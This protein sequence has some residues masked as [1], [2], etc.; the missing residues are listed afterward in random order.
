[1][2]KNLM[3]RLIAL[4]L[5]GG[6]LLS[7]TGVY[8][9]LAT[10]ESTTS[11]YTSALVGSTAE[12]ETT[13]EGTEVDNPTTQAPTTTKPEEST[14][15]TTKP[16]AEK[17]ATT[18]PP[19]TTK[20]AETT[21]K[22][23]TTT[24]P[25]IVEE[26]VTS[27][28][29][30]NEGSLDSNGDW[31]GIDGTINAAGTE[32]NPYN[33][34][35][36][37]DFLRMNKWINDP[38][39][40]NK[41]FCLTSNIDFTGVTLNATAI[42]AQ[43]A[44]A[45]GVY[46]LVSVDPAL[47]NNANVYFVLTT[48]GIS[49]N[50]L[51][52]MTINVEGLDYVSVF[53]YVNS[54]SKIEDLHVT[55]LSITNTNSQAMAA[56]F[57]LKNEGSI[58]G[59]VFDGVTVDISKST[60]TAESFM[61]ANDSLRVYTGAAGVVVDNSGIIDF[62]KQYD[63]S[64]LSRPLSNVTVKSGRPYAG[65]LVAQNRGYVNKVRA[66]NLNV[67]G[68][69][70]V[71]GVVG[72]NM[73]ARSSS[74]TGVYYVDVVYTTRGTTVTGTN[75]VGGIAG[76]NKGRVQRSKIT[77]DCKSSEIALVS[78]RATI[79]LN[80]K[81]YAGG[82]VGYNEGDVQICSAL[83]V[84]AYISSTENGAAYGGI[85]GYSNYT[86][87]NCV[88]TGTTNGAGTLTDIERYVGGIVGKAETSSFSVQ[89]CYTLVRILNSKA[90]LGAVVGFGGDEAYKANR[91]RNVF[92]S[93]IISTRPSPVSYGGT[94]SKE[95]D[96][97]FS[98]PY[99]VAYHD[100]YNFSFSKNTLSIS[101][102]QFTFS[103]WS[104]ATFNVLGNF[105]TAN[106]PSNAVINK[107]TT[108]MTYGLS[109]K[110]ATGSKTHVFYEVDITL[111]SGIGF[112]TSVLSKE[113]MEFGILN[114]S[115]S[116]GTMVNNTSTD[117]VGTKDD[118]FII[119]TQL[120]MLEMAPAAHFVIG[121]ASNNLSIGNNDFVSPITFWGSID[122]KGS[123]ISYNATKPFFKGIYGSRDDSMSI[124]DSTTHTSSSADGDDKVENLAYGVVKNFS[125]VL[126]RDSGGNISNIFGNI[127]NA[128]VKNISVTMSSALTSLTAT[129]EKSG[130]FAK[131]VYGNSYLYECYVGLRE[132]GEQITCNSNG[133]N[134]ISGFIGTI[135]AENA[136]IDNCGSN[137]LI[138][139]TAT[140]STNNAIFVGTIKSLGGAI[141]NCYATGGIKG[142][143]LSS[144]NYLFAGEISSSS[145]Q[146]HN[147]YFSPSDYYNSTGVYKGVTEGIRKGSFTGTCKNYSF[148]AQNSGNN[149]YS[150]ITMQIASGQTNVLIN[151]VKNF[152]R[153]SFPADAI[154]LASYFTL[155][156][157]N[158]TNMTADAI[159]KQ[160]DYPSVTYTFIGGQNTNA[161][162]IVTHKETGLTARLS[163][164]NSSDLALEDNYYVIRTPIDLYYLVTNQT[165]MSA[166]G[167]Y[168]YVSPSSKIKIAADID[169]TGY[170]ID[171]FG[172]LNLPFQGEI[173]G[174]KGNGEPVTISNLSYDGYFPGFFQAVKG[175]TISGIYLDNIT[176]AGLSS[177]AALVN[178]VY[179]NVNISNCKVTNSTVAAP[180]KSGAIIG[181]IQ[182]PGSN[183]T[184]TITSVIENCTVEN[185]TITSTAQ[186]GAAQVGGII[187]TVGQGSGN[188][189]RSANIRSCTVNNCEITGYG[190]Q[191]GG[192]VG[193][194]D[195]IDNTIEGCTV[196]NTDIYSTN[197]AI[198]KNDAFLGGIAG[199]FGGELI[200]N[201][202]VDTVT[203]SGPGAAGVVT[204]LMNLEG[205]TSTISN[206]TVKNSNILAEN[207]DFGKFAGG[208]MSIVS[209]ATTYA[210]SG[211]G[212]KVVSNCKITADTTVKSAVSGGIVANVDT[213]RGGLQI[214]NCTNLGT[215][216]TTG[217]R[218]S[219]TD[220]AG[221]IIG[222]IAS[223][224]ATDKM[225]IIGCLSQGTVKGVSIL[226]G[227]IGIH[228]GQTHTGESKL[229]SNTYITAKFSST[230][231][232]VTK[233]L[234][235]G[236]LGSNNMDSNGKV[237]PE[238]SD[239]V[240]YSSLSN[241][242]PLFGNSAAF[243]YTSYTALDPDTGDEVKKYVVYDMQLG[244]DQEKGLTIGIAST[245]TT[246]SAL[247]RY[248]PYVAQSI[249]GYVDEN[250]SPIGTNSIQ[251]KTNFNTG[252]T[253][254][255]GYGEAFSHT[256]GGTSYSIASGAKLSSAL[257]LPRLAVDNLPECVDSNGD[258]FA[259][260][261][262]GVI[263][264][265]DTA[266]TKLK[267]GTSNT[268]NKPSQIQ[269]QTYDKKCQAVVYTTYTGTVNG[270][271]VPFKVGFT[272]IVNGDHAFDGDGTR[273]NPYIIRDAEDLLSIKMHHDNPSVIN[274][275]TGEK[276]DGAK[277]YAEGTYYE[278]VND[279]DMSE[280]LSSTL[281]F[282][283]IG[284]K[285]DPFKATISSTN[286]QNFKISNIIINNPTDKSQ[287][288]YNTAYG[289]N[290][291]Y[292]TAFGVFGYTDGATISDL[293]FEN[294]NIVAN[295]TRNDSPGL[296]VGAVVGYAQNTTISNVK[297]S[298]V[299][300][301]NVE[302]GANADIS[303]SMSAGGIVGYA[304]TDTKLSD[305]SVIGA[306]ADQGRAKISSLYAIGGIVGSTENAT[307]VSITNARVENVN[308]ENR[309]TSGKSVAGGIAGIFTGTLTGSMVDEIQLDEN[310]N[311]ITVQVRKPIVVNSVN[312]KGNVV[313]GAVGTT[314]EMKLISYVPEH[315]IEMLDVSNV[316]LDVIRETNENITNGVAGGILGKTGEY[317]NTQ[318]DDCTVD[319]NT[320]VSTGLTAGGIV[321]KFNGNAT[322]HAN[323]RS[324]LH[325]TN[326]KS[327]AK[328]TQEKAPKDDDKFVTYTADIVGVGSILGVA[329]YGT[330]VMNENDN[331]ANLKI[332]NS[333][334]GGEVAGTYNVGGI[335]GQIASQRP[336]FNLE[337]EMVYN[338]IVAAKLV[339]NS[340]ATRVGVIFGAVESNTIKAEN[341]TTP[342]GVFPA[343]GQSTVFGTAEYKVKPVDKIFYSSYTTA[344]YTYYGISEIN[345][346]QGTEESAKN[347]FTE[348]VY[349]VN[350]VVYY[351][352][353]S[354][355]L[356]IGI[357]SSQG[358]VIASAY[359]FIGTGPIETNDKGSNTGRYNFSKTFISNILEPNGGSGNPFGFTLAGETF[360]LVENGVTSAN[361]AV[362]T[363]TPT[364]EAGA[365][366]RPYKL[367]AVKNDT[368]DMVF[369][370]TNGLQIAIPIICGV[371]YSG[372]GTEEDPI[373]ISETDEAVFRYIVPI[374]PNYYFKQ[375][376]NLDFTD[377]E[378]SMFAEITG[379]LTTTEQSVGVFGG[380][381]DGGGFEI[382][383][384]KI[385]GA[386]GDTQTSIFGTVMQV[387][388]PETGEL[389][390]G[391][392]KNVTFTECTLVATSGNANVGLV[393]AEVKGNAT[394]ENVHVKDST[395]T[396]QGGNVGGFAGA[397]TGTATLENVSFVSTNKDVP[398]TVTSTSGSVGGIAGEMSDETAT[399]TGPKVENV[400]IIAG[401]ATTGSSNKDIAGGIVAEA[402]GTIG[403]VNAVDEDGNVVENEYQD[404]VSNVKVQAFTSGGAVG[405]T[406]RS[407]IES[408]NTFSLNL[409]N[410]R[411]ADTDVVAKSADT[412]R[413][414][415]A[416]AGLLG[417]MEIS[418]NATFDNSYVKND[419]TVVS[420][421]TA[422]GAVGI[423]PASK[424]GTLNIID[425]ECYANIT[426]TQATKGGS[427]YAGGMVGYINSSADGE[428]DLNN[429]TMN[430]SVAGG[431]IKA[432]GSKAY[433]GGAIGA[434]NEFVTTEVSEEFFVNGVLSAEVEVG[435]GDN[436]GMP[437]IT[438][439]QKYAKFVAG[440][441]N[442]NFPTGQ[443]EFMSIFHDNYYS[444]Y[445]QDISFF[446][447]EGGEETLYT[448]I[449]KG[450]SSNIDVNTGSNLM[451]SKDEV[452]WSRAAI[453]GNSDTQLYA[454][455]N[456]DV[457]YGSADGITVTK[458]ISLADLSAVSIASE[459]G[460]VTLQEGSLNETDVDT[461]SFIAQPHQEGAGTLIVPY[462]CGLK[463]TAPIICVEMDGEGTAE[464]PFLVR[465]VVHLYVVGSLGTQPGT[466]FRQVND[467]DL[468]GSYNENGTNPDEY[469]NNN[470]GKGFAPIGTATS[471]FQGNYD[472]Q[473]YKI[474]GMR[475]D[476]DKEDYVG[477]FGYTNNAVIKNIHLELMSADGT[478]NEANG[479]VGNNF[480]G[481][482]IGYAENTTVENCS[483]A[484]GSVTGKDSVGG[485]I[486][487]ASD[488]K[489][490]NCFTQ[491]DV[492][493]FGTGA[494][495]KPYAAGIIAEIASAGN[496]SYVQG[497]FASG[498][499]YATPYGATTDYSNAAGIIGY[500]NKATDFVLSDC[501]FTGSTAGGYGILANASG[502]AMLYTVSNCIDA[503]MNTAMGAS[504][505]FASLDH[506]P[507][508]NASAGVT[509]SEVYY[510]NALL[511]VN[512][513]NIDELNVNIK[514]NPTSELISPTKFTSSWDS[515]WTYSAGYYPVPK[516]SNITV[517]TYDG[518]NQTG[519][520]TLADPYSTAYARFLSAPVMVSESE[521]DND[522]ATPGRGYGKGIVYPVTLLADIDTNKVTYSS[523][524]FDTS[525]TVAYPEGYDTNLYGVGDN[526]NVDLLF[527]DK[528]GIT[529]VYR[530]V[531][532][533]TINIVSKTE[534][535]TIINKNTRVN[536]G[537]ASGTVFANGEAYYNT[538]VPMV[539][540]T[541]TINGVEVHRE[542]KIPL[543][544]GTTYPIATQRQLFALGMAENETSV[545]NSKFCN[546]YGSHYNYKLITDVDCSNSE[547]EFTPIGYGTPNG[548]TGQFD[549]SNHKIIGLTISKPDAGDNAVG[550]FATVST[551]FNATP[552]SDAFVKNLTLE[553]C[554]VIGGTTV[555]TLIGHVK[556]SDVI[557]ENCHVTGIAD[558]TA[559]GDIDSAT[560]NG[561]VQ[562]SGQYLGGLIGKVDY[563]SDMIT[564][565]SATNAVFATGRAAAVGGLIG[566]SSGTIDSCYAT[567]NVVAM[568]L[569]PYQS[570][571][572]EPVINGVGGLI[573]VVKNVDE[574]ASTV[575]SSFASGNVE[576]REFGGAR[577]TR[578]QNGVGGFIGYVDAIE[579][580]TPVVEQCFSGG[581]VE[582]GTGDNKPVVY[583]STLNSI[584]MV[585]V[586]GFI[587]ITN[588]NI[589]YCYSS[590]AVTSE[591]SSISKRDGSYGVGTGGVVGIA[592]DDV[593]DVYSS[594]S[595]A[596][597]YTSTDDNGYND[598]GGTIGTTME[599]S[600]KA[601]RCYFDM[602]TNSNPNLKSVGGREDN[603]N[604][605]SLTTVELTGTGKPCE[606]WA[607]SGWG[608]AEN[609]YPYLTS[610]LEGEVD[611]DIK[612]NSIL[613]VICV[614]IDEDDVSAKQGFG[615]TMALTVPTTFKYSETESYTLNWT[616]ATLKGNL[617]TIE[618]T[619]NTAEYV[620][621]TATL[622]GYE[623]NG[624]RVYRR[625]CA[626]MKGTYEQPYLIGSLED[627]EHVNMTQKE[628]EDAIAAKPELYGQWA[629]PLGDGNNQIEGT[630]HY[631]LSGPID[632]T[633]S[634]RKIPSTPASYTFKYTELD[635]DGVT[636]VGKTLTIPYAGF[637]LAGNAYT[638][639]NVTSNGYFIAN[640][641]ENSTVSNV[642][643]DNLTFT[644]TENSALVSNN[645]GQLIDVYV[646]PTIGDGTRPIINSAGLVLTNAGTIDGCVVDATFIGADSEIGV[647]A[648]TNTGTI[649]NS[650]TAGTV[651]TFEGDGAT[652]IGAFVAHNNGTISS[653][654]SMADIDV[655]AVEN[656]VLE[657][658]S[659]FAATSSGTIENV[660]TRTALSVLNTPDETTTVASLVGTLT[661]STA[662]A[663]KNSYAIGL[664]G[665]YNDN[666]DSIAFGV[667]PAD[668]AKLSGVFVDKAIAGDA[669]YKSFKY[670]A[671]TQSL[672]EM[673]QM[674]T[675]AI[676]DETNNPTGAFV[677]GA[678]GTNTFPQL[679][680]I[681][682]AE[683]TAVVDP[684]T[685]EPIEIE[686]G[687]IIR[688]YDV[689]KAYSKM[690]SMSLNTAYGQY[691][692]RLATDSSNTTLHGADLR[693]KVSSNDEIYFRAHPESGVVSITNTTGALT[694]AINPGKATLEAYY[695]TPI[696]LTRGTTIEPKLYIDVETIT[697]TEDKP[698]NPNFN[699]GLG[700]KTNPYIIHNADSLQSLTYY[701]SDST[702]YFEL[703]NDIDMKDYEFEQI[704]IFS[705]HL[706]EDSTS[707]YAIENLTSNEGGIFGKVEQ[708]AVIN[709]V[710][711]AGAKV[712]SDGKYTGALADVIE[713]GTVTNCV[714]SADVTSTSTDAGA[715]TGVLVGLSSG[716]ATVESVV[717]TGNANASNGAVG[718][719]A[720]F[721]QDTTIKNVVSTAN[722]PNL[723]EAGGI[724]G[725]MGENATVDT[726]LYAGVA[727]SKKPIVAVGGTTANVTNAY[728]DRQITV[729]PTEEAGSVIGTAKTTSQCADVFEGNTDFTVKPS[730]YPT[731]VGIANAEE[732]SCFAK[733]VDLATMNMIFYLGSSN[734]E[735]GYYTSMR[736]DN[737]EG[738][739]VTEVT[740]AS[741][742][743]HPKHFN[744]ELA[745]DG[746]YTV[747]TAKYTA[748]HNP[749]IVITLPNGAT[750]TI[751]PGLVLTANITYTVED[752][753][754]LG[755]TYSVLIK[756]VKDKGSL[757]DVNVINDFTATENTV[758][759]DSLIVSD[760]VK[761][762][763]VG[764]MLPK[765]YKYEIS[766][767]LNGEDITSKIT[768][769]D[770]IY[771]TFVSLETQE[772]V[773]DTNVELTLKVVEET[774][775]WGVQS[776]NSTL[777]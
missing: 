423:T 56:G 535:G 192:I 480:V 156:S 117:P 716:N 697:V 71:G 98:K 254:Y 632:A 640:L 279:I 141:I 602:W 722:V 3:K 579:N 438:I 639:D 27:P 547:V 337:E 569:R 116:A 339:G 10:E 581:N 621:V 241:D 552:R 757:E 773:D 652:N 750:R 239:N 248:F 354:T 267:L 24:K 262:S 198:S 73:T 616:G 272:V 227:V 184:S 367:Q 717:T 629:T 523:S 562:G 325:I 624:S 719:V 63:A 139:Q 321:G 528:D 506:K 230:S 204:N 483:V 265:T 460:D 522:S 217:R 106:A 249:V 61:V 627:L 442:G 614:N 758:E 101:A 681:L 603:T 108:T 324:S 563:P 373:T 158:T 355:E 344:N 768:T 110:P 135:D 160:G 507:V 370:Y 503:G 168:L 548:Y 628:L 402:I 80:D 164:Y 634:T 727:L 498:S 346:Y 607:N 22:D 429:I 741:E 566:H 307:G 604:A 47:S 216:E 287:Y 364:E 340:Q 114:S 207:V 619:R 673:K 591:F 660:Y 129:E 709:N 687:T 490:K 34:A 565:C 2:N 689:I 1:M 247:T 146:I 682:T 649:K 87:R 419:C 534:N 638:I 120:W 721:A 319:S 197:K 662:N 206:C 377:S 284:T 742:P 242:E 163:V 171:S 446:T 776:K 448:N 718:G 280:D 329:A 492:N 255:E 130:F 637:N 609:A 383:G 426:A 224:Q 730:H 308:L 653:C 694:T 695:R 400:N 443:T 556:G 693:S 408:S 314:S 138:S 436:S 119:S 439:I 403:G 525:D 29:V 155:K 251:L 363:L 452:D 663:V 317:Y 359:Q 713:G 95:G 21:T 202:T 711:I 389:S 471:K 210:Y 134:S 578:E 685:K 232:S 671:S 524:I 323:I 186:Q 261:S 520:S 352:D 691:A 150:D 88:A 766:A 353:A 674:P 644:S 109:S 398:A 705:G 517:T 19:T 712:T 331:T 410:I 25:H 679:N 409:N 760:N 427:A 661:N 382:K 391:V 113:P 437:G 733:T 244:F 86:V 468:S 169:M 140:G 518:A 123:T 583:A 700:T 245:V 680:A 273:E 282:A 670:A 48:R 543:S 715:A 107:T 752:S 285:E 544:Y 286:G 181:V 271:T 589:E 457:I 433:A 613:S 618:R 342:T 166:N 445:P 385:T 454:K 343:P 617:A 228:S 636:P 349:D 318:I 341:T 745:D 425:T 304:G 430:G 240:V 585:G 127:C 7:S 125:I 611:A 256:Y 668:L 744:I 678:E 586:G 500:L 536:D 541:A 667:V 422:G 633:G 555:G 112:E 470:S 301:I 529:T 77:D 178:T 559:D 145:T 148:I 631:R 133:L 472:G 501:L 121:E 465:R 567:G 545:P 412:T 455:L 696:T 510:D 333:T 189:N 558:R 149:D 161:N 434:I 407:E 486:G 278:V 92:Y 572:E 467:I 531:F 23:D 394:I 39:N 546:Y 175:A 288:A 89:N 231:L 243:A 252:S 174:D 258:N 699:G 481:G 413:T 159:R 659:G 70:Y 74:A 414:G 494:A 464:K 105:T 444:S 738:M 32:A 539:N 392:I 336:A 82:I 519:S 222:R 508:T 505:L 493:A 388:D 361:T 622:E 571:I 600:A 268:Y 328:I 315:K 85:V 15:E 289:E 97:V 200:D 590:A 303:Y 102:S 479:I 605:G 515:D 686:N 405:A 395:V 384:L 100:G 334:A 770:G 362:F 453:L 124:Y 692:D 8:T 642:I 378:G 296:N 732:N 293:E 264:Q 675:E 774:K 526:K 170:N 59:C 212:D 335:A 259:H 677:K 93:S 53:G 582:F 648:V 176:S 147:C 44:E 564:Q 20:P 487:T 154:S 728:Y 372:T 509:F 234:I 765:G 387:T 54:S 635:E 369:T 592:R 188:D 495:T 570:G 356:P 737:I 533:T 16:L 277:Y 651:K 157:T 81:G 11:E 474:T 162:L 68:T 521:E 599:T 573:G 424:F 322:G 193:Y 276:E 666:Q 253:T 449:I 43:A 351:Y 396:A 597:T 435:E 51:Q 743:D 698:L 707:Q 450:D 476:R 165:K 368:A 759:L 684:E 704:P 292:S 38:G 263:F 111:P 173:I 90:V 502:V 610:L 726:A 214:Q 275:T 482:I 751:K 724:V 458:K 735:V 499:I 657:N 55:N 144:N 549:G 527:E 137:F 36:V 250:T 554:N 58:T 298:G 103:G 26:T 466:Y 432:I 753:I 683:N 281:A 118:P 270:E 763:Y 246:T 560:L 478:K 701:G 257:F 574:G 512:Q 76:Y 623:E 209:P 537:A 702:L 99:A 18:T 83:N 225:S 431:N 358:G 767:K 350:K 588:S 477:L 211:T 316:T 530:N 393:A 180:A 375:T 260:P 190:Y 132:D 380:N 575:K 104:T 235:V 762:F 305:V 17:P 626:D 62:S 115:S 182:S 67:S 749:S 213:F 456:T 299:I 650:G 5:T 360:E 720:G 84:G 309:A 451:L 406:Y 665:Y 561:V 491:S 725:A 122:L 761:G 703:G 35:D 4:V 66:T 46:S 60:T 688:N 6:I 266:D 532:D 654:F 238:I 131:T 645:K 42:Q 516:V 736:F 151:S 577:I 729:I 274:K 417:K 91:V 475:M 50:T 658:I 461:F 219:G 538:Q 390:S 371:N 96:L 557:I 69:E 734:G 78:D 12:S 136:L 643:F 655:L 641:D 379:N 764:D 620:D 706:N 496:G 65:A 514:G 365:N 608:Y 345:N 669:S 306:D 755:T 593:S 179:G 28:V 229:I 489:V 553:N 269:I 208:I 401:D 9:A 300:D 386:E 754:G 440:Y 152:N 376:G 473:G 381:Y 338:C 497:C 332:H 740:D 75:N 594:G 587:G 326:C 748:G 421:Y 33:V 374:L 347:L 223:L 420:D 447:A 601:D 196:S 550:M 41:H 772:G 418:T 646:R 428:I 203:V 777:N 310:N 723:T 404:A 580:S 542:I 177:A 672:M 485:I 313:G 79:V 233:G 397:I 690:S 237:L 201:C 411:I 399:I 656:G 40:A 226:G 488:P 462:T 746:K 218:G 72:T 714:V 568:A 511:K 595:V 290:A 596:V 441:N 330:Y 459:K 484:L 311:P 199:S 756:S 205:T 463:T 598:I 31:L 291:D 183:D 576:V 126:G 295:P 167:E 366:A 584:A 769:E 710:A 625:L 64:A 771:G 221:G 49:A 215:I 187:G 14:Q 327:Y 357:V 739:T 297:V 348:T 775:P 283:P 708:G 676:Y 153:I 747:R 731:P 52:N 540:A 294:V 57:V 37:E 142:D 128:T 45:G 236:L 615:V 469:I 664:L 172:T 143:S 191:V 504:N 94:G 647:M 513:A 220:A 320:M 312:V 302:K 416:A 194:T 195:H 551:D 13:T 30:N 606:A 185:T 630:V 612:V 415:M